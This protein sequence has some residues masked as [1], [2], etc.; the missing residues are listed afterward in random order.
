MLQSE[1][2]TQEDY[3][4]HLDEGDNGFKAGE[5]HGLIAATEYQKQSWSRVGQS[6]ICCWVIMKLRF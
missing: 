1:M 4:L 2:Y 3:I 5:V 6:W